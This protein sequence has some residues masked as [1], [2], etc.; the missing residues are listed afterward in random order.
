MEHVREDLEREKNRLKNAERERVAWAKELDKVERRRDALIEMRADGDITKEKF[1]DKVAELDA[2][3]VA[4]ERELRALDVTSERAKF[5]DSLP[6]LIEEYIR[7]LPSL[8][9]GREGAVRDHAY[10]DE[11]EERKRKA[12]EEGRLPMF[13]I[14]PEMFRERTQE[15]MEELREKQERERGQRYRAMYELLGLK[16]TASKD[17]TLEVRGTFGLRKVWLGDEPSSIWEAVTGT[18]AQDAPPPAALLGASPEFDAGGAYPDEHH[19]YKEVVRHARQ[20]ERERGDHP[21]R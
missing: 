12:R 21:G 8:V 9:H 15:E 4:A 3:K 7:E 18:D 10:T 6:G 19:G 2:R 20:E 14:S 17:K 1:R 5:L 16:I 11:H 13:P